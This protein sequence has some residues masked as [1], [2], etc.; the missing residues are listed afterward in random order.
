M[1]L[2][3]INKKSLVKTKRKSKSDIGVC[4]VAEKENQYIFWRCL[5]QSESLKK[6]I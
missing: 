3:Y 6:K 1:V 2:F 5:A 4:L